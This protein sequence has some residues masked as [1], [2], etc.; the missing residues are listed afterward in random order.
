MKI[1]CKVIISRLGRALLS[2][3]LIHNTAV[4]AQPVEIVYQYD[5]L[6]RLERVERGDGPVVAYGYDAAGNILTQTVSGSPDTDGDCIADFAGPNI[7]GDGLPIFWNN[8]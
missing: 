4:S 2:G 7:D 6:N 5:D 3:L 1:D 8:N